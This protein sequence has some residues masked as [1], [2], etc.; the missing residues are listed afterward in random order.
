MTGQH[1][2]PFPPASRTPLVWEAHRASAVF[3]LSEEI[4]NLSKEGEELL[5]SFAPACLFPCCSD[6]LLQNLSSL[7]HLL[8]NAL[9]TCVHHTDY[10][11]YAW[12]ARIFA[13]SNT[14]LTSKCLEVVP[15]AHTQHCSHATSAGHAKDIGARS[16]R[17]GKEFFSVAPAHLFKQR[18]KQGD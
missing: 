10:H 14:C 2:T 6:A 18:M 15:Q 1:A 7:S 13:F 11:L 17:L 12:N 3:A 8:L 4:L 5:E 16:V 9:F